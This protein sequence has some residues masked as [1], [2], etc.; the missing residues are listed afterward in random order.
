MLITAEPF[1]IVPTGYEQLLEVR[2]TVQMT[3]VHRIGFHAEHSATLSASETG[4]VKQLAIC[5]DLL[6]GVD[7]LVTGETEGGRV[8]RA[9]TGGFGLVLKRREGGVLLVGGF[10]VSVW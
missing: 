1:V 8:A 7:L 3:I 4:T 2:Q 6:E 10:S 5:F 9:V